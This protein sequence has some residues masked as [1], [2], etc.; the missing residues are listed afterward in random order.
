M[1]ESPEIQNSSGTNP[2]STTVDRYD[3]ETFYEYV[4]YVVS[5]VHIA[6]PTTER[7]MFEL[8]RCYRLD[9][10]NLDSTG[11]PWLFKRKERPT[12]FGSPLMPAAYDDYESLQWEATYPL[13]PIPHSVH[14]VDIEAP[15]FRD[16]DTEGAGHH[17]CYG[18][19]SSHIHQISHT[20]WFQCLGAVSVKTPI[21]CLSNLQQRFTMQDS[22]FL[23]LL[24]SR[25]SA[26][27][28]PYPLRISNRLTF[29]MKTS[30]FS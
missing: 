26:S 27:R 8:T 9:L 25:K 20:L 16:L 29:C 10:K 12:I 17:V 22:E 6:I 11:K 14:T 2:T 28:L 1:V 23:K 19:V 13:S 5:I 4:T 30:A 24:P 3:F 7:S 21:M 15:G 18:M